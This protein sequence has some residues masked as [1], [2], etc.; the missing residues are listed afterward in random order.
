MRLATI[1]L[2]KKPGSPEKEVA[3][4]V[5]SYGIV[6][7]ER[8]NE[9]LSASWETDLHAMICKNRIPA[10][11]KWHKEGGGK[12]LESLQDAAIPFPAVRYAPLYRHPKKIFGIGLNYADHAGD[13]AEKTPQGIPASFFKPETA[14]IGHGDEIK[15][16]LQSQ[17]TTGEAEFGVIIG[18]ECENIEQKDW[19]SYVAGFTTIIDMTAEDI[20]RLNP[21]YLTHVKSFETFFSFGPQLVTPDEFSD[22]AQLNVQTVLNGQVTAENVIANMTFPPDFL[23]AFHSRVFKW[24]P[25]DILSTG[26]PRAVHIQHGDTVECR[27]DGF[28]PLVNPVTDKKT[29]RDF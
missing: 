26:T 21:R 14:I 15:I 6:P 16:P 29:A 13:L 2:G 17:K 5:T 9:K 8:I 27:I 18:R 25:G 10:L 3:G 12:W 11:T 20:L 4:I 28:A 19:L 1:R 23:V 24:Q 7:L 22:I